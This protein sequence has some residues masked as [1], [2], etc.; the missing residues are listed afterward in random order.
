M[1]HLDTSIIPLCIPDSESIYKGMKN[2][3]PFSSDRNPDL[4]RTILDVVNEAHNTIT[5]GDKE[6]AWNSDSVHHA[7]W[8]KPMSEQAV[9]KAL[10]GAKKT[11]VAGKTQFSV[12][13]GDG[14]NPS[15]ILVWEDRNSQWA[16][17]CY[18]KF[19][20]GYGY[21]KHVAAAKAWMRKAGLVLTNT[22]PKKGVQEDFDTADEYT[23]LLESVLLALCDELELDPN[24]LVEAMRLTPARSAVLDRVNADTKKTASQGSGMAQHN[25]VARR[26]RVDSLRAAAAGGD[27]KENRR[28]QQ[29]SDRE[30]RPSPFRGKSYQQKYSHGS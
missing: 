27:D 9:A 10:S 18:N 29:A 17:G 23:E 8:T 14:A 24:E 2:N 12:V 25:A 6:I 4:T 19:A 22:A 7:G 16:V 28:A 5:W 20:A 30:T 1:H 15:T 3:T 13:A 26:G 11:K 21:Q